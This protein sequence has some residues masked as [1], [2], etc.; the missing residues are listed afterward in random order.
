MDPIRHPI[1]DLPPKVYWVRRLVALA[2][3]ILAAIVL[4]YLVKAAFSGDEPGATPSQGTGP[5]SSASPTV[6]I[7]GVAACGVG[8]LHI[9]LD[10]TTTN[11]PY[12]DLPIFEATIIQTGLAE[13][14]LHPQAADVELLITSGPTA[15]RERY[16]SNLDCAQTLFDDSSLLLSPNETVMLTTEWPRIRSNESCQ[17]TGLPLP[18]AGFYHAILTLHGVESNDAAFSI[19]G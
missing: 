2:F 17:T 18:G 1:G 8:D 6:S 5:S 15:S 13:C 12:P 4:F 7:T 19:S 11:F 14:V 3:V 9:D 16:W 10:T